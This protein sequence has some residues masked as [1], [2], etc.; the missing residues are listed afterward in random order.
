MKKTRKKSTRRSPSRHGVRDQLQKMILAG[1][2]QPGSKLHQ[3]ELATRFHSAPGVIREALLEL[4]AKGLVDVHDNLGFFVAELR[5]EGQSAILHSF[6][7][8]FR[9]M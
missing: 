6:L 3:Q 9:Y 5:N 1:K 2:L 7:A 8:Q 4:T